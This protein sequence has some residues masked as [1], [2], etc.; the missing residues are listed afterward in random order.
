MQLLS[1]ST[2]DAPEVPVNL[3]ATTNK[4]GFAD[5]GH[6]LPDSY[7]EVDAIL[8]S[9]GN[10]AAK[11]VEVQAVE[12]P[13][14]TQS[15]VTPSTALI[16]PIVSI[17]TDPAGNPTQLNLWVHD[18]EPDDTSTLPM[19]SIYQVDLTAN[20][21][22]QAS[23]MGPNF[24]NLSFGP[25]NLAVGQEL[26]VH[27]AY[28]KPPTTYGDN[29]ALALY[30]RTHGDLSEITVDAGDD[31]FDVADRVGRRHRRLHSHSLLHAV[32]GSPSTSSPTT[33]RLL[34]M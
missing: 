32:E 21:T 7:V 33:R 18:A 24:A 8:D 31:E 14:P 29:L 17:Q 3:T 10:L 11:T 23:V 4:I 1:P 19:D 28:T 22:Y 27:G 13:F 5:L 6:L 12:N 9:Q 2:A 25:Q 15:G 16:G 26:V 30:R 34:S 20:P